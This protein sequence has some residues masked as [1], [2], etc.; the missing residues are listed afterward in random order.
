MFPNDGLLLVAQAAAAKE[1]GDA[2]AALS[3]L[4]Q[5]TAEPFTMPRRYRGAVMALRSSW[6]G[7][8]F[9]TELGALTEAGRFDESRALIAQH[10]ADETI[11][12]PVRAMLET[13]QRDLP[14]AERP[15]RTV[16]RKTGAEAR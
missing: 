5:S 3:L 11:T 4:Q 14:G 15:Q 8:W 16:R 12:G 2:S 1:R 10:L 6:F 7:E 9:L 13:L